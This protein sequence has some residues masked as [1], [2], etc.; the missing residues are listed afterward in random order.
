MDILNVKALAPAA[1]DADS[2]TTAFGVLPAASCSAK[3]D[4]SHAN[5]QEIE[6]DCTHS[7]EELCM[8]QAQGLNVKPLFR[9]KI[10]NTKMSHNKP[11]PQY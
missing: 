2:Q 8:L 5:S 7:N 3:V 10:D 9:R 4:F 11:D 1:Q 6:V